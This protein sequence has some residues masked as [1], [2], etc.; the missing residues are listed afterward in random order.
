MKLSSLSLLII[1]FLFSY[2]LTAQKL[3][4]ADIIGNHFGTSSV[5]RLK[6]S[7]IETANHLIIGKDHKIKRYSKTG[8][9]DQSFGENGLLSLGEEVLAIKGL[10]LKEDHLII[11]T[12]LHSNGTPFKLKYFIYDKEGKVLQLSQVNEMSEFYTL[13]DA[14]LLNDNRILLIGE[15]NSMDSNPDYLA[16]CLTDNGIIDSTFQLQPPNIENY[17]DNL[18]TLFTAV[19]QREDGQLLLAESGNGEVTLR[20]YN[21]DGT[22]DTSFGEAG[23]A[24][25]P[26]SNS[27]YVRDI[28]LVEDKIIVTSSFY[29]AKLSKNGILDSTFANRGIAFHSRKIPDFNPLKQNLH[30]S[31]I[32]P[33]GK[34]LLFGYSEIPDLGWGYWQGSLVRYNTDGSLDKTF[35]ND[36]TFSLEGFKSSDFLY[37]R[38]KATGYQLLFLDA[39]N[40]IGRPVATLYTMDLA[41]EI[42]TGTFEQKNNFSYQVY[43]N[44]ASNF[45]TLTYQLEHAEKVKIIISSADGKTVKQLL[46]ESQ[47][48]GINTQLLNLTNFAK[49]VYYARLITPSGYGLKKIIIQ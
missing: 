14:I 37:A 12:L 20:L 11:I 16:I 23:K 2:E 48:S 4:D 30:S 34:I 6:R 27:S 41:A 42:S 46:L 3:V 26:R 45:L 5:Y 25:L 39:W 28:H 35:I 13:H 7:I 43:P 40:E 8:V 21:L 15:S 29:I 32:E 24:I 38:T 44:P 19:T 10:F 47:P 1:C 36:G 18:R 31:I 33:G 22:M 49:G 17:N 9:L